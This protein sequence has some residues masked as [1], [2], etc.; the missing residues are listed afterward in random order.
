MQF[1]EI[2]GA[3][4]EI[5]SFPYI[6]G[7]ITGF[8]ACGSDGLWPLNFTHFL[9]WDPILNPIRPMIWLYTRNQT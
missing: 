2:Y 1:I 4:Y 5:M 7:S 6:I 8:V 9:H 3:Q